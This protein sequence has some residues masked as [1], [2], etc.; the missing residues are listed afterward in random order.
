M[1]EEAVD[2]GLNLVC[3]CAFSTHK[4]IETGQ[5]HCEEAV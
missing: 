4:K 2:T 3:M 1:R 5:P